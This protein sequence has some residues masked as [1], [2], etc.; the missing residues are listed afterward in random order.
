MQKAFEELDNRKVFCL[1]PASLAGVTKYIK[2]PIQVDDFTL[3]LAMNRKG[4]NTAKSFKFAPESA[5]TLHRL[6]KDLEQARKLARVFESELDGAADGL[7]AVCERAKRV[8]NE[9]ESENSERDEKDKDEEEKWALKKELDM[10]TAYLRQVHMYCYYC[11]LECDSLEEINR[12]CVNPH[13]RAQKTS[14][15]NKNDKH[16]ELSLWKI[17]PR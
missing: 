12:R 13:R 15:G 14:S 5:N 10:I 8:I 7:A 2:L 17:S 4:Q 9:H 6:R 16:R 1:L 3:H 11:A